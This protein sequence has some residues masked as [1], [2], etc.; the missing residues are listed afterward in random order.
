MV[1]RALSLLAWAWLVVGCTSRAR[2]SAPESLV[3]RGFHLVDIESRRV[4]ERDVV[5]ENGVV[6]ARSTSSQ[7]HVVDGR[8]EYLMPALWDLK[9]SLW[10]NNSTLHWDVLTQEANFT[11]CLGVHL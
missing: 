8:G 4:L 10:G 9:A 5:I 6:V 11:Q 2:D 1:K 3:L 7:Q